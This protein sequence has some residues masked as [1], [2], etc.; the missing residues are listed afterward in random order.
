[1]VDNHMCHTAVWGS[2]DMGGVSERT[3]PATSLP[4]IPNPKEKI[5]FNLDLRKDVGSRV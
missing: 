4:P 1:M 3:P 5:I 2:I